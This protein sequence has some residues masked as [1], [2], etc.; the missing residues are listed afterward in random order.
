[1]GTTARPHLGNFKFRLKTGTLAQ[2]RCT[3]F[4]RKRSFHFFRTLKIH[5]FKKKSLV[6]GTFYLKA[7]SGN[8]RISGVMIRPF[9]VLLEKCEM[10]Q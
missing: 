5:I 3:I 9:S 6:N 2:I 8:N 10:K 1:M 4:L 7:G